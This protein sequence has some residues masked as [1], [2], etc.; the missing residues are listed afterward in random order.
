VTGPNPQAVGEIAAEHLGP[1]LYALELCALAMGEAGRHEEV[2][3]YRALAQRLAQA[4][5]SEAVPAKE[6]DGE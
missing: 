5:G 6:S 1:I 3:Y 4:G 2:E